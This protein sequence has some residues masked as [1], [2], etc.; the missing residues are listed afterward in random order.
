VTAGGECPDALLLRGPGM[1]FV[2]TE[3][4]SSSK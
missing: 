1:T 4:L 2:D 3:R